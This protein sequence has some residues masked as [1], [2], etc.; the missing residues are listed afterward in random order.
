[1]FDAFCDFGSWG[2]LNSFGAWGWAGLVLILIAWLGL[3][4]GFALLA[5]WTIRRAGAR[6]ATAPHSTG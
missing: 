5:A 4:A 6:T 3:S 1:M 2:S